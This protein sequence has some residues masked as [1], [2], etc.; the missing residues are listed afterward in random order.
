MMHGS[1]IVSPQVL[2][3]RNR[4]YSTIKTI[5]QA[6]SNNT[7]TQTIT[8]PDDI[9]VTS[10]YA[11]AWC[12]DVDTKS[13]AIVEDDVDRDLFTVRIKVVGRTDYS[14]APQDIFSFNAQS[15]GE[16]FQGFIL[17]RNTDIQITVGHQSNGTVK[18][19][20]N[21]RFLV[22]LNGYVVIGAKDIRLDRFMGS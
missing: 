1:I 10:M 22:E 8:V 15:S 14:D 2:I 12:Q 18:N 7:T 13:Y 6:T 4:P 16:G 9:L 20:P 5:D 3:D 21:Y 19:S 11:K 17:P